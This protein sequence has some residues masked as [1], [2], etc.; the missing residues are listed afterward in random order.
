VL[1]V[2]LVGAALT[3]VAVV[4][5][6]VLGFALIASATAYA[7]LL[8]VDDPPLDTRAVGVAA[9]LVVVGELVGWAREL[10]S[11]SRD[12]PGGAWR[13]AA[14]LAGVAAL[15]LGVAWAML[16]LVD[17][18]RVEGLAVEAVGALAAIAALVLARHAAADRQASD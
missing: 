10:D 3:A 6:V 14:W 13:R 1:P 8:V 4:W 17:V 18:V 11:T 9:L 15:A 7:A 16:A 2:G 5:P 12:E